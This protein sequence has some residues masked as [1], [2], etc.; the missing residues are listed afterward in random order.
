MSSLFLQKKEGVR[1]LP[2]KSGE[3]TSLFLLSLGK[4]VF[5]TKDTIVL[6]CLDSSQTIA[7][8]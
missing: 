8:A 1:R 4:D 6:V 5:D 3:L 7:W 2:L